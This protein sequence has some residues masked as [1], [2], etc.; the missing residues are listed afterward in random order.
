[1]NFGM[2]VIFVVILASTCAS[3]EATVYTTSGTAMVK[4]IAM[5]EMMSLIV[6]A[7]WLE[8]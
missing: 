6:H 3:M 7:R 5:M 2:I 4:R 8:I 1:M